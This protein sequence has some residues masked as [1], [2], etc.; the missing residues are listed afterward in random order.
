VTLLV[1]VGPDYGYFLFLRITFPN[2]KGHLRER[3]R[4]YEGKGFI[5]TIRTVCCNKQ[6]IYHYRN[7][8]TRSVFVFRHDL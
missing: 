8:W 6:D 5:E 7:M 3:I 1:I 2:I 4:I